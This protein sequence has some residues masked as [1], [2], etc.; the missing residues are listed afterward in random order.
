[1]TGR[2]DGF[3][4][5]DGKLKLQA[6]KG[7]DLVSSTVVKIHVFH[8]AYRALA[9]MGAITWARL[10]FT[11]GLAAVTLRPFTDRV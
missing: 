6:R 8:F 11:H 2:D 7:R 9:A 5:A 10:E 1:V 4:T 3:A